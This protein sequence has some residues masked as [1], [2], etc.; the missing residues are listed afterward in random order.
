MVFQIYSDKVIFL[1]G[2]LEF[3]FLVD[4]YSDKILLLF[5]K[6]SV[7]VYLV[8]VVIFKVIISIV[9]IVYFYYFNDSSFVVRRIR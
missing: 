7:L 6:F 1:R 8:F 5:N 9:F 2:I 3:F 4:R